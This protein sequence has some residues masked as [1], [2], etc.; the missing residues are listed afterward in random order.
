MISVASSTSTCPETPAGLPT[1]SAS[2]QPDA[3][4]VQVLPELKLPNR[5]MSITSASSGTFDDLAETLT[6]AVYRC[7]DAVD[8][9]V[10]RVADQ[11]APPADPGRLRALRKALLMACKEATDTLGEM[12]TLTDLALSQATTPR[13]PP[14]ADV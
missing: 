5:S 1:S 6:Q 9:E 4:T 14:Q 11:D 2:V 7:R 10:N 8:A 12:D 3:D 13:P